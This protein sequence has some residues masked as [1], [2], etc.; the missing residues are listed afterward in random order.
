MRVAIIGAGL[1][2]LACAQTLTQGGHQVSVFE[3]ARGPGGRAS[4]R[5]QNGFEFD[6]GAQ[7]FTAR[8]ADF[9]SRVD[10]WAAAGVAA[11][12][13]PRIGVADERGVRDKHDHTR[14][15][16]GTPGMSTLGRDLAAGLTIHNQA[17]IGRAHRSADEWVLHD[18]TGAT[19]QGRYDALVITAPPE[20]AVAFLDHAPQLQARISR[21]A[22]NPCWA[23]MAS[24]ESPLCTDHD[25]L[26]V[27]TGHLSWAA[28][29]NSK[30]GRPETEC[31]VLHGSRDWSR[32]HLEAEPDWVAN[33]L[34]R[35]LAQRLEI[36]RY[37]TTWL[38]AHRWRFALA[39]PA[40]E[41]GYLVDPASRT[42]VC[43]DWCNGSRI[44]G[45][46]GS[47][48]SAARWLIDIG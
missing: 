6:H 47:G 12:W 44:E 38:A 17:R 18:D 10:R 30:P 4:R 1:S 48:L 28:R 36:E 31:W 11:P 32:A 45:A 23:V 42:L 3:K 14:R 2:G 41:A 9:Q 29:N 22:M 35:E 19:R 43:G 40:L 37:A 20:Q 24:F 21:V 15:W 26:F 25:A 46:Y 27:N 13:T 16:V 33:T 34:L 5:R 7:Y 8:G 39:D